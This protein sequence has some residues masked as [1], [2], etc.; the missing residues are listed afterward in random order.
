MGATTGIV[1]GVGAVGGA[2]EAEEE[3]N[4]AVAVWID[5]VM[6]ETAS[7][8]RVGETGVLAGRSSLSSSVSMSVEASLD[9]TTL[10]APK[11]I[12]SSGVNGSGDSDVPPLDVND[13]REFVAI[14]RRV[15]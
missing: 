10:I 5:S 15:R 11:K 6:N 9:S 3:P 4:A 7:S 14:V 12:A 2:I 8:S 1:E 13:V